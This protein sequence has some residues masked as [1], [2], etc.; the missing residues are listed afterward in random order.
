MTDRNDTIEQLL[1]RRLDGDLTD[2]EQARLLKALEANAELADVGQQYDRLNRL[3]S[4][5][6]SLPADLDW[7]ALGREVSDRVEDVLTAR[8]SA[9]LDREIDPDAV[10]DD[11]ETIESPVGPHL[12]PVARS[13]QLTEDCVRDWADSMPEVD[14]DEYKTRVS[15][16]VRREAAVLSRATSSV[17]WRR[18]AGWL[19]PIAAAVALVVWW[20]QG[21]TSIPTVHPESGPQSVLVALDMPRSG[22]RISIVFDEQP[23]ESPPPAESA[24]GG[25][26]IAIGPSWTEIPDTNDEAYYY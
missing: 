12:D 23:V 3:L 8:A 1:S 9:R 7:P 14:W 21:S 4:T 5:W 20:P 2:D 13:V 26:A 25:A 11:S 24:P 22:G 17:R 16:S 18:A 6:R 19:T 15:N 10:E